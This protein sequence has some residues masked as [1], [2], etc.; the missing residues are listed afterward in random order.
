[1]T[2]HTTTH[3]QLLAALFE[4]HHKVC[5]RDNISSA[6]IVNA[7]TGS[8]SYVQA[9]AAAILTLGG[10]HAPI[11][12]TMRLLELY[13]PASEASAMLKRGQLVPGWGGSFQKDGPD[14]VWQPV[15]ALLP[16]PMRQKLDSVTQALHA[17]GK[18]IY[19]NP[20]AYTAATAILLDIPEQL[21]TSLLIRGRL[22]GWTEIAASVVKSRR[23]VD[24]VTHV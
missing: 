2:I 15:E 21:A 19:P 17:A 13:D 24:E 9:V 14:P 4:A 10:L 11:V 6:T 23:F 12:Q 22:S 8:G 16:V 20:S 7:M 18:R 5:F 1:M 3:E